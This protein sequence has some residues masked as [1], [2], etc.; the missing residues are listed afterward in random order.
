MESERI[1]LSLSN[2]ILFEHGDYAIT[3]KSAAYLTGI[4][5]VFKEGPGTVELRGYAEK[6]E[7]LLSETPEKDAVLLSTKR[8][9]SILHFL[10]KEVKLPL[11]DLVAHG[12]GISHPDTYSKGLS[13]AGRQGRVEIIVDYRQKIPYRYRVQRQNERILDFKGFFF[14]NS[15]RI[16]DEKK[17]K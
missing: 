12:F 2:R 4:G 9:L 1:I 6:N 15:S 10:D 17:E 14:K 11:E 16:E 8:A 13:P 3:E 5:R 7:T